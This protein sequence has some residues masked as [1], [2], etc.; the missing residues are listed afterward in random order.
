VKFIANQKV[1]KL[2]SLIL[3]LF[4]FT[5]CTKSTLY[6]PSNDDFKLSYSLSNQAPSIGDEIQVTAILENLTNNDFYIDGDNP[7]SH[8]T[9]VNLDDPNSMDVIVGTGLSMVFKSHQKLTEIKKLKIEKLG[10][11]SISA[12]SRFVV[13]RTTNILETTFELKTE[14]TIFDI[15]K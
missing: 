4:I 14:P 10:K 8:I 6:T 9:I 15:I 12:T 7:V 5:S 3:I 1:K 13:R 2:I 11:Y